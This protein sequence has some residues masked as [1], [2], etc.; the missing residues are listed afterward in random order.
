MRGKNKEMMVDCGSGSVKSEENEVKWWDLV[1]NLSGEEGGGR[2]GGLSQ[3]EG[4]SGRESAEMR[5]KKERGK[6]KETNRD[7]RRQ[8]DGM[9]SR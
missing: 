6:K 3:R 2:Q 8:N 5:E 7:G 9:P 4:V 1:K